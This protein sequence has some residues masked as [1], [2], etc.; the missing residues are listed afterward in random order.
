MEDFQFLLYIA[1]F[2]IYVVQRILK[3]N[4]K[5]Q[6][7]ARRRPTQPSGTPAPVEEAETETPMTFQDILKEISRGFDPKPD[8]VPQPEATIEEEEADT[9]FT[10]EMDTEASQTYQQSIEQAKSY[11]SYESEPPKKSAFKRDE[12][13]AIDDEDESAERL[14]E[15][16]EDFATVET[17]QKAVIYKEILDRKHF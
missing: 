12:D 4:K 5:K 3:G 7:P 10:H 2:L 8:A 14:A 16:L 15:I 13:Y 6:K 1:F 9:Y 11:T 17:A